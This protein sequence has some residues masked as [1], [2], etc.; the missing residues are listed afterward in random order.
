[1]G[2]NPMRLTYA[3][4]SIFA[5]C[6]LYP[7]N[8]SL[9]SKPD[10]LGYSASGL[11]HVTTMNGR[12]WTLAAT[13]PAGLLDCTQKAISHGYTFT[14]FSKKI[15]NQTTRTQRTRGFEGGLC[16]PS[17][18][19]SLD[20]IL[21]LTWFLPDQHITSLRTQ[22]PRGPTMVYFEDRLDRLVIVSSLA[23]GNRDAWG[24]GLGLEHLATTVG[25]VKLDGELILD[26]TE[27]PNL[28]GEI[29]FLFRS[30]RRLLASFWLALTPA[31]KWG[32]G[33]ASPLGLTIDLDLDFDGDVSSAPQEPLLEDVSLLLQ[34]HL[35]AYGTPPK[36]TTYLQY[37]SAVGELA[38]E[39][40]ILDWSALEVPLPTSVVTTSLR[41]EQ[42]GLPP[43]NNPMRR[44]WQLSAGYSSNTVQTHHLGA[45]RFHCGFRYEEPLAGSSQSTV[46]DVPKVHLGFAFESRLSPNPIFPN[47]VL[48]FRWIQGL[49][50]T[51]KSQNQNYGNFKTN[52][53][54]LSTQLDLEWR[55]E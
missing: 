49:E 9:A 44:A 24:V 50:T 15:E 18:L 36:W 33:Y 4:Q 52:L 1:M 12:D 7:L 39:L 27:Q 31:L 45:W 23:L 14:H 54:G 55:W 51:V 42:S 34:S 17:E 40:N 46:I 53:M 32:L 16:L 29:D 43:V 2:N 38:V 22:A 5:L 48:G 19:W 28:D 13:H 30:E 20:S 11:G 8:A 37:E 35:Y 10:S 21:G 6:L 41:E 25:E 3:I 47:L 26:E